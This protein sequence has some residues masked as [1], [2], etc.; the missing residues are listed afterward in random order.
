MLGVNL[1]TFA[2]KDLLIVCQAICLKSSCLECAD[3]VTL[4]SKPSK[5]SGALLLGLPG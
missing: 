4:Y 1:R 2:K 3:K 5:G